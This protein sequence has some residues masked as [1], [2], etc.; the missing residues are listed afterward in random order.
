MNIKLFNKDGKKVIGLYEQDSFVDL[1]TGT[2]A[3]F[4]VTTAPDGW[5]ICDGS[6]V[7]KSTYSDLASILGTTYGANTNGSGGAGSTHVRL[8]DMRGRVAIG[9]GTGTGLTA[10]S[11]GATGGAETVTL[12]SS[13]SGSAAH[14]HGITETA[15]THSVASDSH[16]HTVWSYS[17]SGARPSTMPEPDNANYN[18]YTGYNAT[19]STNAGFSINNATS[20][21]TVANVDSSSA[22][23]AH[24]NIQPSLVLSF[25]IKT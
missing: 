3:L 13:Q 7:S 22:S 14:V 1:P 16:R 2:I 24:N 11:L 17:R 8:P 5:L 23:S 25:I 18:N 15:H 20:G 9:S 21:V 10:R 19:S 12:T 6:E 4:P